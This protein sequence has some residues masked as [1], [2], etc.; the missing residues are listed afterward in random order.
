MNVFRDKA[1]YRIF[2]NHFYS[3]LVMQL[4]NLYLI[5][6]SHNGDSSVL[7]AISD[8]TNCFLLDNRKE[9]V[10]KTPFNINGRCISAIR[11]RNMSKS[12]LNLIVRD[13]QSSLFLGHHPRNYRL[14]FFRFQARNIQLSLRK[15]Q[16]F[17]IF[18]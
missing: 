8:I 10:I 9:N 17:P 18:F 4:I 3:N 6:K 16:T 13:R 11:S 2:S 15:R 7:I 12:I 5:V 14:H 1:V